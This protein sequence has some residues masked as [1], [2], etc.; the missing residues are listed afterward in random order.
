[1]NKMLYLFLVVGPLYAY[2]EIHHHQQ[3]TKQKINKQTQELLGAT[4]GKGLRVSPEGLLLAHC[5]IQYQ[6]P[7]ISQ[8]GMH[9][10][11]AAGLLSHRLQAGLSSPG[12]SCPQH[13]RPPSLKVSIRSSEA[14]GAHSLTSLGLC[15][16]VTFSTP[17]WKIS[18]P[19]CCHILS[20]IL[21]IIVS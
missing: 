12:W 10:G 14:Q 21:V 5:N 9:G 6:G 7:A 15:G 18:A 3:Q 2:R 17:L 4:E 11:C 13:A 20:T 1:M 8:A 16:T 19:L